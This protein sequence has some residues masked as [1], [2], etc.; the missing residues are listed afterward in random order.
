MRML[1]AIDQPGQRGL[2]LNIALAIGVC[3]AINAF[4]FGT[5]FNSEPTPPV[6]DL[7]YAPPGFVVGIVWIFLYAGMGAARHLLVNAGDASLGTRRLIVLLL[8]FCASYPFYTRGFSD[9]VACFWGNLATI[10]LAL[11]T[12]FKAARFSR[13]AP[14][15][16]A[17]TVL[18][19]SFATFVIVR[20]QGWL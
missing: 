5:G 9:V 14:W 2:L 1:Q 7:W 18:W 16:V 11:I 3:L 10:A 4:V 8:L 6:N 15:L 20:Q 17:P 19:V 13:V 12:I